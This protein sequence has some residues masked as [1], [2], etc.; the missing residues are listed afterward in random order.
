MVE[1]AGEPDVEGVEGGDGLDGAG[2]VC[3]WGVGDS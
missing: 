2:L 3:S 1:V